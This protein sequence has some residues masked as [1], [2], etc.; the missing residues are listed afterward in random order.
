M[1]KRKDYTGVR[2]GRLVVLRFSR[3]VC[4]K[5]C[6]I[7]ICDCGR[8]VEVKTNNLVCGNTSSCGCLQKEIASS[9][10]K[11]HSMRNH[12]V[13]NIW[14]L[15]KARCDNPKST[16]YKWYGGIGITYAEKWKDFDGFWEDMSPTYQNGFSI[17]RKNLNLNYTPDNC[18]W[19]P[20]KDQSRNV[21]MRHDNT[22]GVTGVR[23]NESQ[24]CWTASWSDVNGKRC[25]KTFSVS[26]Y[27]NEAFNLA[28]VA[29]LEAI[30]KLRLD[31][32]YCGDGH[33]LPKTK[34]GLD[35]A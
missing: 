19:I 31:G 33:G 25:T 5:S 15:I 30:S 22:S 18:M 34:E 21:S 1:K 7:C 28:C 13:Y 16:S 23:F 4:E 14:T 24:N 29:R 26:K 3:V 6:W 32:V 10:N 35:N 27:G 20:R 12:P 9:I 2:F 17:E 11:K 8:E